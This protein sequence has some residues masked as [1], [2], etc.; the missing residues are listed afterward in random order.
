MKSTRSESMKKRW[1]DPLYRSRLITR[2][3]GLYAPIEERFWNKVGDHSDPNA[4][5]LWI[6]STHPSRGGRRYGNIRVNGRVVQA[7]RL[8]YELFVG[9]IPEGLT[10]DHVRTRGCT[11][12]LCVNP[13][14]L[15]PVTVRENIRR[16][17]S[18]VASKIKIIDGCEPCTGCP[19][20]ARCPSGGSF[21]ED[22]DNMGDGEW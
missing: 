20:I 4:C 17:S 3:R 11:N 15:E 14:H 12:T 7:H 1:A 10:I 2:I 18:P 22:L 9:P 21:L 16:G 8:S 5:W 6:G 19:L 13:K